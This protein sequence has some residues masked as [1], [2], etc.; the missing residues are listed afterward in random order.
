MKKRCDLGIHRYISRN[1]KKGYSEP[2]LRKHLL[3]CG[4]DEDY[5]AQQF[6]RVRKIK[7]VAYSSVSVFIVLLVLSIFLF[8][9]SLTGFVTAV[10]SGKSYEGLAYSSAAYN[11]ETGLIYQGLSQDGSE[12]ISG[13]SIQGKRRGSI[14]ILDYDNDG[15]ADLFT[16]GFYTNNGKEIAST[17]L[18]KGMS[19]S[20]GSF[21]DV[22]YSDSCWADFD[23]DGWIEPV[24]IGF[25]SENTRK[26]SVYANDKGTFSLENYN[27]DGVSDGKVKCADFDGDGWVDIIVSG[28]LG[29]SPYLQL[30][31]NNAGTLSLSTSFTGYS[32]S[33]ILVNDFN[34]DGNLDF[35]VSGDTGNG[36]KTTLHTTD[37]N[38]F[39]SREIISNQ[40]EERW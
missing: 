29:D 16:T 34:K 40:M 6:H 26:L 24:I 32:Y 19:Q 25:D 15:K 3:D 36:Y 33:S 14:N 37:G 17:G 2:A 23:N 31:K 18:Y 12:K 22:K 39:S 13:A 11:P 30:I 20:T 21:I 9:P 5:V 35:I 27:L 8:K 28:V 38:S 4:F 10:N 1:L 7:L